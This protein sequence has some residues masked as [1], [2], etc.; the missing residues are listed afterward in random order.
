MAIWTLTTSPPDLAIGIWLDD[1]IPQVSISGMVPLAL[2][3]RAEEADVW[4]RLL[5]RGKGCGTERSGLRQAALYWGVNAKAWAVAQRLWEG[6][7]VMCC[8][9]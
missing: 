7:T 3:K 8:D 2:Q 1:S 9:M 6:A 4:A 5:N